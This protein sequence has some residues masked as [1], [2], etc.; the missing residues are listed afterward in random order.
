M[1]Q[2][3]IFWFMAYYVAMCSVPY[4]ADIIARNIMI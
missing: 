4:V 3:M 2:S 1:D